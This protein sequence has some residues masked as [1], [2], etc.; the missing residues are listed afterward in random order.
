MTKN[1]IILETEENSDFDKMQIALA[2]KNST[3]RGGML[4]LLLE[5]NVIKDCSS[6]SLKTICE[7]IENLADDY[8]ASTIR[9]VSSFSFQ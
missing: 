5:N 2:I 9:V 6:C 4:C 1:N 8:L 7:G 3:F